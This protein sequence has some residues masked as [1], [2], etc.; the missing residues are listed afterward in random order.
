MPMTIKRVVG[1]AVIAVGLALFAG[2]GGGHRGEAQATCS[3]ATLKGRYIFAYDGFNVMGPTQA[4]RVPFASAGHETYG[5]DGAV[6]GFSTTSTN[7]V[8]SAA[9]Y[10][11]TY[12]VDTDCSGTTDLTDENGVRTHYDIV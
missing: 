10:S 8:V 11:G 4:D 12:T 9:A 1:L 2:C 6:S 3:L 7:G 5:G